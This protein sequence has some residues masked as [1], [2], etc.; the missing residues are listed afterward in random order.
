ME[1]ETQH[2]LIV[3]EGP[4]PG[5]EYVL[6]KIVTT[7]GRGP[8]NDFVVEFNAVSS[9]H[10]QITK[11]GDNYHLE[12]LGSSNGTFVNDEQISGRYLLSSGDVIGL[13][14]SVK[15]V[16]QGAHTAAAPDVPVEKTMMQSQP[17]AAG[18]AEFAATAI[19]DVLP[20]FQSATPP[21][22]SVGV[23]GSVPMVY[24]LTK[25]RITFGRAGDN[26]I[27]IGSPI[28]SRKHG[29]F[30]RTAD[31]GYNLVVLP[32]AGN[33]VVLDG[34]LVPKPTRLRHDAKMRIGGQDPGVM[35]S[36]LYTSP[37]EA[38]MVA[39]EISFGTKNV[40]QIGRDSTNDV[41][42]DVPQVS[43]FHTQIEKIGQ[44]FKVVDLGSTNGTF[45]N[46]ERITG[47]TWL[48]QDDSIRIGPY[49]Y[50][51]GAE[52]LAQYDDSMDLR[53]EAIGLNKWVHPDLNILQNISLALNPR[54]FIVVVGQSGGGKSTLVDAI[55]GYRP[56][57]HG[58]VF[59]N[60][61]NV[62]EN[63]DSIRN[64]I[65][66]VPQKDIIHMELTVYDALDYTAQL[67]LPPDTTKAERHKR[68]MEVLE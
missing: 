41:V 14:F 42:L 62:Y 53:V 59:V 38:E 56:A 52:S 51:M 65:G 64:I 8:S 21:E 35:V 22:L 19:G 34:K 7:I 3:Q 61:T 10:A 11:V 16:Y 40:I 58:D 67:R 36:M 20:E 33:P 18:N 46:D 68:I 5:E 30:E 32:E 31:G 24:T 47:E 37:A 28:V 27:V 1:Q 2:K 23:A 26:D 45:V 13:G 12:D 29:Y 60:E 49:R 17:V 63:F 39:E 9:T 44:R 55:A 4:S 25:D 57:T 48:D 43:R 54:E 15:I 6:E 50:V 66:F